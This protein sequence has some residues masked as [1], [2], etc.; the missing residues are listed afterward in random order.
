MKAPVGDEVSAKLAPDTEFV[1]F[2][3]VMVRMDVSPDLTVAMLDE[4]VALSGVA[5]TP[6]A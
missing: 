4:I 2:F 1:P 3:T 6:R 5:T